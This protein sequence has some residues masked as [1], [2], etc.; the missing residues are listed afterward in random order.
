[1]LARAYEPETHLWVLDLGGGRLRVGLDALGVETSGTLA[2]LAFV[3]TGTD[4]LRGEPFGS[5]EAAKFVGPFLA[6]VAGRLAAVNEPV[7]ANPSL[8][9]RDPYGAGWLVEFEAAGA[10]ALDGLVAGPDA[11]AAWFAASAED[12]RLKGVVAE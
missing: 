8:V 12:Y 9:E 11:V 7:L 4:L 2:A 10:G 1:D 6:P 5:L 3:E